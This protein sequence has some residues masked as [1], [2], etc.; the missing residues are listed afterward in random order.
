MGFPVWRSRRVLEGI[1]LAFAAVFGSVA[2]QAQP[3]A[4]PPDPAV[5]AQKIGDAVVADT[6][7]RLEVQP[8]NGM[9]QG[10]YPINAEPGDRGSFVIFA[11]DI[12]C[13]AACA[14]SPV[15]LRYAASPGEL[16]F[17]IDGREIFRTKVDRPIEPD[18]RDYNVVHAPIAKRD[19]LASRPARLVILFKPGS[20]G[21]FVMPGLTLSSGSC[22]QEVVTLERPGASKA[23]KAARF[24]RAR[25]QSEAEISAALDELGSAAASATRWRPVRA[26]EALENADPL[27]VSDWRYFSGALQS[28]MLATADRFDRPDF[29]SYVSRYADFFL[30]NVE[31][32]RTERSTKHQ[33]D[34]PFAHYFR[35]ALLDDIGPQSAALIEW[36][37]RL[38]AQSRVHRIDALKDSA[39]EAISRIPRLPDG[40]MARI[41]PVSHTVW[42]DDLFMG[43][44]SL[45]RISLVTGRLDLLNEA[46]RQALLFDKHLRD[47]KSGLY[48]HG[49][50]EPTGKPSSSKWAR[51]NGWTML[52]KLQILKAL[53]SDHADRPALLR[54]FANHARSLKKAQDADGRWHQVLDNKQTYLETSASAMFVAAM[55]EGVTRGW[56]KSSEFDRS[57]QRGW[58]AV[59]GQVDAGGRAAGI[60]AG[61]PILPN[62]EAYDHQKTRLSDPRGLAAMLYAC[63]AVADWQVHRARPSSKRQ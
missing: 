51:A 49:W 45:A 18:E 38:A 26:L 61:T 50:F 16:R 46:A 54:I 34:G 52:A 48:Y 19:V 11:A 15:D 25:V 37:A 39:L 2:L 44:A 32:V 14:T 60:V 58:R 30:Q 33:L 6:V 47:P 5:I 62:D 42:A 56:L 57:I 1:A 23:D 59:A 43:A 41:T 28:A 10:F 17:L 55:A 8:A 3:L 40:T 7:F 4:P 22:A 9:Q 27:D 29:A 53:P 36:N 13:S 24:L 35:F 63:I 21:G 31:T 20:D 12:Q